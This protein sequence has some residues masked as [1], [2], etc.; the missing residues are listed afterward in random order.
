M[1][2]FLKL[3]TWSILA[4]NT[5]F[6]LISLKISI[7]LISNSLSFPVFCVIFPDWKMPS[8]FPR[9]SSLSGNPEYSWFTYQLYVNFPCFYTVTGLPHSEQGKIP[10]FSLCVNDPWMDDGPI[11]IEILFS[12]TKYYLTEFRGQTEFRYMWALLEWTI[13]CSSGR[14]FTKAMNSLFAPYW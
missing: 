12:N 9:F 10:P 4:N 14:F 8:H 6:I 7:I 1:L 3:K 11:C 13:S 2:N 5:Q